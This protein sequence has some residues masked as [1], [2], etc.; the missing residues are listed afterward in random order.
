ME[1]TGLPKF[2]VS[3]AI[4]LIKQTILSKAKFNISDLDI[5][6]KCEKIVTPGVF[7]ASKKDTFTKSHHSDKL[8]K[9]YKGEKDIIYFEGEHNETRPNFIISKI[10]QFLM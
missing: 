6:K 4:T 1:K 2:I 10:H 3:G 5:A 7:I 8:F 9:A